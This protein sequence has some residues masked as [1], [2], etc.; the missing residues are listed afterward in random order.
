MKRL[1]VVKAG[2]VNRRF[3]SELKEQLQ[4]YMAENQS[5]FEAVYSIS[6][7][8]AVSTA[9]VI[10]RIADSDFRVDGSIS[11][12]LSMRNGRA[13]AQ[14]GAADWLSARSQEHTTGVIA[15]TRDATMRLLAGAAMYKTNGGPDAVETIV[16]NWQEQ[17]SVVVV[18][19]IA[20]RRLTDPIMGL[21]VDLS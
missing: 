13:R 14:R 1:C 19:D 12:R 11:Q 10:D 8:A 17:G 2:C 6:D 16:R 18:A 3:D 9:R 20:S 15:V 7:V 5:L 4:D 21:S